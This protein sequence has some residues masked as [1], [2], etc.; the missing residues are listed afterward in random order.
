MF[1]AIR[2]ENYNSRNFFI[3]ESIRNTVIENSSFIRIFYSTENVAF[4]GITFNLDIND[5]TIS[6]YF[7]KWRCNFTIETNSALLASIKS[8]ENDILEKINI[9]NKSRFNLM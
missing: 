8:I 5:Y 1:I 6:K 4:N 2:L 3:S 7:N 9:T